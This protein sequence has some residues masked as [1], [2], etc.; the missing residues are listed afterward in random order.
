MVQQHPRKISKVATVLSQRTTAKEIDME[1]SMKEVLV[2]T[3][4]EGGG[5]GDYIYFS[6]TDV[7]RENQRRAQSRGRFSHK[8]PTQIR[9]KSYML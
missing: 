2:R 6:D 1:H 4:P 8:L 3:Q 5:G 7:P 9:G